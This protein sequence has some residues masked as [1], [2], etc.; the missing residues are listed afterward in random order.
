[1]TQREKPKP[2]LAPDCA[3]LAQHYPD[4]NT[5]HIALALGRSIPHVHAQASRM[6]LRKSAAFM[7]SALSGRILRTGGRGRPTQYQPGH[8][9]WNKGIP[10][11]TG[12]HPNTAVNHFKPGNR[13]LNWAPVGSYRV[14]SDGYLQIKCSDTGR[15]ARDWVAAHRVVWEAEHGPVPSGCIVAFKPGRRTVDRDRITLDAVECITRR[16][17]MHRNSLHRL[18]PEIAALVHLR[19]V[20][21]RTINQRTKETEK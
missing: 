21:T 19:G 17:N 2:W 20:L 14:N 16:E 8:S 6:G 9:T 13:P 12:T 4:G 15:P 3:Y 1:M 7:S 11:S 10:K 18:P 5:A